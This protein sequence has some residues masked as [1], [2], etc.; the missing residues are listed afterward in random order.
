[1]ASEQPESTPSGEQVQPSAQLEGLRT[2]LLKADRD[3]IAALTAELAAAEA[4][5]DVLQ[6]R[7]DALTAE[8][9]QLRERVLD[10][11]QRLLP[12]VEDAL[13]A[14]T[15]RAVADEPEAMAE[16]LAP[17]LGEALQTQ[18]RRQP[19][20]VIDAIS[21][22]LLDTIFAT[23]QGLFRDFQARIDRRLQQ[24]VGANGILR[25]FFARLRGVS[26]GELALRDVL[27]C[28][29][30]QIFVIHRATGL[31]LAHHVVDGAAAADADLIGGMLTAIRDFVRDSF[32]SA[33]DEDL[34][35]IQHGERQIV[36]ESGRLAYIAVVMHGYVPESARLHLRRYIMQLHAAHGSELD[37]FAHAVDRRPD[38]TP[39]LATLTRTLN[40]ADDEP[41]AAPVLSSRYVPLVAGLGLIAIIVSC[42]YLWFTLR[43]LPVAITSRVP[44]ATVTVTATWTPTATHTPTTTPSPTPT[45]TPTATPT[46]TPSPTPTPLPTATATLTPQPSPTPTA[47]PPPGP[48][49]AGVNVFARLAP[50]LGAPIVGAV[51]EGTPVHILAIDGEWTAFEWLDGENG[52]KEGWAKSKYL[53]FPEA[54]PLPAP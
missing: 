54:F 28:T 51:P 3:R 36:I 27:P 52:W 46:A 31:L 8:L 14:L 15:E 34:G 38:F 47:T 48:V 5:Q 6:R 40:T 10:N 35:E 24:T 39:A 22:I 7:V 18:I 1:M 13:P 16:A 11:E 30:E 23:I 43:L 45:R 26:P 50:E 17:I 29:V 53:V 33:D 49:S 44:T 19:E 9:A 25:R 32:G 21:P 4:D 12:A 42:F 41:A 37:T 20:P 2:L